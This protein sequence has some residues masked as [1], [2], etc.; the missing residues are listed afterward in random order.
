MDTKVSEEIAERLI[1]S[2]LLE[3]KILV[4]KPMFD[5]AGGDLIGFSTAGEKAAL[6]RIQCKY[7]D[8]TKRT[9]I[10]IPEEYVT[11]AFVLFIYLN[12]RDGPHVLCLLP[13]EVKRH[14]RR[15]A[16]GKQAVYRLSLT[17]KTGAEFA[18][19]PNMQFNNRKANAIRALM[20]AANPVTELR[21]AFSEVKRSFEEVTKASDRR[22]RLTE[23]LYR[24][25]LAE[26]KKT[27]SE[28][29]LE[30][31]EGQLALLDEK[32]QETKRLQ[33]GREK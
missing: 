7:R 19:E 17:V 14:F 23:L 27:A 31:L 29:V 9:K 10:E 2:L 4:A 20:K 15:V 13:D 11:G 21:R 28:E 16:G 12:L 30:L 6:C 18:A 26:L 22:D 33:E 8:C 3:E 5:Q 32:I 24:Y 25:R 1:S